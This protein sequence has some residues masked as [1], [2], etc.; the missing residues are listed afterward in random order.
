MNLLTFRRRQRPQ[1]QPAPELGPWR[2]DPLVDHSA[3]ALKM[4]CGSPVCA[5]CT[6]DIHDDDDDYDGDGECLALAERVRGACRCGR[7]TTTDHGDLEVM[8]SFNTHMRHAQHQAHRQA[9][10]AQA[11]RRAAE[12]PEPA[13]AARSTHRPIQTR[14]FPEK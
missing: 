2:T 13:T 7:W 3:H 5:F 12:R 4:W 9:A 14:R 1:P 6:G 11:A 10:A 8:G